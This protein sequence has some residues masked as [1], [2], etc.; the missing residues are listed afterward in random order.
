[1]LSQFGEFFLISGSM[2]FVSFMS[3]GENPRTPMFLKGYLDVQH[4]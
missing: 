4:V 2:A 1:M 3:R